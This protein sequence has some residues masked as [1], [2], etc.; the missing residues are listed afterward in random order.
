MAFQVIKTFV[1][2]APTDAVWRFLIDPRQVATCMPGAAITN[3]VDDRTY[4]GTMTVRV[5]PVTTS[6]KGK[7]VFERLD[8]DQHAAEIVATGQDVKGKG[9]ASMKLSSRL[10]ALSPGETEI[11]A[12]SD[13]NITGILAQM[14]RGMIQDVSD[15]M[16]DIFSKNVREHLEA[17]PAAAS[18]EP[19][20]AAAVPAAATVDA[21]TETRSAEAGTVES[22]ARGTGASAAA[23]GAEGRADDVLDLGG[24][25]ARAARRAAFRAAGSPL[26]W[27][28]LA[29]IAVL[30]YLLFVR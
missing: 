16:F 27:I 20:A 3:Q 11:T 4:A 30:V 10:V 26:F 1:V 19:A 6:Y 22:A 17:A 29:V 5:G 7:V 23:A 9:G 14:G 28:V 21:E 13:V 12:T 25:G 2:K 15:E 24:I 18:A 8:A